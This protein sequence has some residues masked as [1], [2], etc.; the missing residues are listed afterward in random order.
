MESKNIIIGTHNSL[1]ARPPLRWWMHIFKP[2]A[3]CQEKGIWQQWAEGIRCFD[4]RVQLSKDGVWELAHGLYRMKGNIYDILYMFKN[5]AETC[6]EQWYI[7]IILEEVTASDAEAERF[8]L[9]C[10]KCDSLSSRLTFFGGNRKCDWEQI[11]S[12]K[13]QPKVWQPVSSMAKDARW[14]E[15][16]L[17]KL[18]AKRMNEHNKSNIPDGYDIVLFDFI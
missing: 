11:Y 2:F 1:T 18:Y 17:P 13:Y 9:F 15:K 5:R 7:R 12:F 10:E 16:V 6:R 14:Y 8:R 4:I 3:A